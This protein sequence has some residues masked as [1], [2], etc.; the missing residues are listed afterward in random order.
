MKNHK[1]IRFLVG[2]VFLAVLSLFVLSKNTLASTPPTVTLGNSWQFTDSQHITGTVNGKPATFYD[3]SPN[4]SIRNF[5]PQGFLSTD[6]F[7]NYGT[8]GNQRWGININQSA[9][10]S[11][12]SVF[13]TIGLGFKNT[14]GNNTTCDQIPAANIKPSSTITINTT[15][16]KAGFTW[17]GN[18]IVSSDGQDTYQPAASTNNV[19]INQTNSSTCEAS[20]VIITSSNSS[21]TLYTLGGIS[22]GRGGTIGQPVPNNVAQYLDNAS[23]CRLLDSSNITISGTKGQGGGGTCTT[24]ADCKDGQC[25]TAGGDCVAGPVETPCESH[26]FGFA[27]AWAVCP[28]LDAAN[29]LTTAM[30]DIFEGQLNFS[31]SQLGT[32]TDPNS[33]NYKVHQSWSII[34]DVTSALVVIVMLIV[35]VSQASSFGPLDA[36]TIRK[37]LPRLI[38]AVILIQI[39]WPLFNYVITIVNDLAR[40]LANIM[41]LPFGGG[42]KMD[43]WHLLQNAKLS[44]GLLAAM[45]WGAIIVFAVLTVAFL[46]TM[47]GMAFVVIIALFFGVLTLIFRK[48]LII[49]L[50]IFAPLALLAWVL[51]GTKQYW[52]M[53]WK[54]FIKV[55]FMF[56]IIVAIIAA[57]WIFAYVVGSQDNGQ[58]LNLIFVLVGFFGPMFLLP[59]TYRWGGQAMQMAGNGIMKASSKV[60]ER[61]E[62]FLDTRQQ[63]YSRERQR[64]AASRIAKLEKGTATG[65]DKL[66]SGIRGDYFK[67]GK[68][69]PTLGLPGSRRRREQIANYVAAG[70]KAGA[71]EGDAVGKLLDNE[72]RGMT[73]GQ[74]GDLLLKKLSHAK[75]GAEAYVYLE[76][77]ARYKLT[78]HLKKG[79]EM[80]SGNSVKVDRRD[81]NGEAVRDSAGNVIQEDVSGWSTSQQGSLGNWRTYANG[82]LYDNF[83]ALDVQLLQPN[84]SKEGF[85]E[86]VSPGVYGIAHND[87]LIAAQSLTGWKDFIAEAQSKGQMRLALDAIE[88]IESSSAGD[89]L[90]NRVRAY[91]DS[92]RTAAGRPPRVVATVGTPTAGEGAFIP[93]GELNVPH[94]SPEGR[95]ISANANDIDNFVNSSGGWSR[96]ADGDL[97]NI[98]NFR[99]GEHKA[100]AARELRNRGLL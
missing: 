86:E 96:L 17:Q 45:D 53:W 98:Y 24:G 89:K 70:E 26:A 37:M 78:D 60:S 8:T 40:G 79:R 94:T 56:P 13:A 29:G 18:N 49:L 48:V 11:S 59:K 14:I 19:F 65:R 6:P 81:A 33:G 88:R 55:L 68:L 21:G 91:M 10:L 67:S 82:G 87:D 39:S 72:L 75:T 95:V 44:D 7:C 36:Y 85:I 62:K 77:I 99:T 22:T 66:I 5:Q 50:L 43:L 20:G 100:Q 64:N 16:A 84:T 4:D 57:G 92:V 47:L 80:I 35:V 63:G 74:A 52:D 1:K 25:T 90:D 9:D 83:K 54:N 30:V 69:D 61:P 41:Y 27:F 12:P 23:S 73:A 15:G 42:D 2:I 38:A 32:S 93:N 71:E 97:Y 51:P 76:R 46:F 31:V 28:V 34:K 3:S 58:L